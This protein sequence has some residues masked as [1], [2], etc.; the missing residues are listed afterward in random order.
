MQ[1]IWLLVGI[2]G[3]P[4]L[5]KI[6]IRQLGWWHAQYFWKNK[7]VMFQ[8]T[9][10]KCIIFLYFY[11]ID[12]IYMGYLTTNYI[13][14]HGNIMAIQSSALPVPMFRPRQQ[15]LV[16]KFDCWEYASVSGSGRRWEQIHQPKRIKE[17]KYW[18]VVEPT[19]L[20]NMKV[21]WDDDIPNIWEHNKCS[22]PPTRIV[23]HRKSC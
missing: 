21:I 6:R 20:E 18:L 5:K 23:C 7:K 19:P 10:Q 13:L 14:F 11:S 15:I 1:A 4:N 22:K 12:W 9:T 16:P 3:I 8:T 2:P 17:N